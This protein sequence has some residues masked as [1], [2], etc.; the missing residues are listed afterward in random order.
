VKEELKKKQEEENKK[1]ETPKVDVTMN[2]GS[3]Q[4]PGEKDSTRMDVD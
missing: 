4:S 2:D 3:Q 1:K